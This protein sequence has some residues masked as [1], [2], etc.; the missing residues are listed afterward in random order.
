MLDWPA[1]ETWMTPVADWFAAVLP[2][3]PNEYGDGWEDYAV[4]A[5]EMGCMALVRLGRA[6]EEEWGCSAVRPPRPP[7]VTPRWDDICAAVLGVI[8]QRRW[9]QFHLADGSASV[10]PLGIGVVAVRVVSPVPP[11]TPPPNVT[12][13]VGLG[14][15]LVA[16]QALDILATLGLVDDDAWT[17]RA[18]FVLWREVPHAWDLEVTTD[19]RFVAATELCLASMPEEVGAALEEL[20]HVSAADIEDKI[21]WHEGQRDN[22]GDRWRPLDPE[23]AK[24]SVLSVKRYRMDNIFYEG[25]RLQD[26][27]LSADDKRAALFIFHD[28][29]AHRM[30][31]AVVARMFPNS[32]MA[33]EDAA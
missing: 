33:K 11:Q 28:P 24:K 17:A 14:P 5:H 20:V 4:S 23:R 26:G 16:D 18:E 27:W 3:A 9:I 8:A 32:D 7:E 29:L 31:K 2:R 25:W 12:A 13:G 1:P 10:P 6:K 19:D 30:R 22:M 21:D 15:A